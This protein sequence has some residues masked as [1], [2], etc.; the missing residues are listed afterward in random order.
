MQVRKANS[1]KLGHSRF[2]VLV[3]SVGVWES[4][5]KKLFGLYAGLLENLLS[6][7]TR[8]AEVRIGGT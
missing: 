4:T 5:S 7:L 6:A 2:F 8:I 1:E 3:Q